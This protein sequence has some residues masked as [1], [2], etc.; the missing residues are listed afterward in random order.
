MNET[1]RNR[2]FNI[3]REIGIF[4]IDF[5]PINI[6]HMPWS[7]LH[8]TMGIDL[9]TCCLWNY[10]S[11][12]SA[13]R[14]GQPF[15]PFVTMKQGWVQATNT[16]SNYFW[17]QVRGFIIWCYNACMYDTCVQLWHTWGVGGQ[18]IPW[19]LARLLSQLAAYTAPSSSCGFLFHHPPKSSSEWEY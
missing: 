10:K 2:Y 13:L 12:M 15:S 8:L 18:L 19:S 9:T 1:S 3:C 5:D 17:R 14:M 7:D 4:K 6:Y 16:V 11:A